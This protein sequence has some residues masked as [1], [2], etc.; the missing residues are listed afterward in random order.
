[1]SPDAVGLLFAPKAALAPFLTSDHPF[2]N[3]SGEPSCSLPI[4]ALAAFPFDAC[5]ARHRIAEG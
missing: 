1:M 4:G 2:P 5:Y 3:Q